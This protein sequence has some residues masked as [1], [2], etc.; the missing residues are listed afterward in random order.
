MP[1][2]KPAVNQTAFLKVGIFGF[3]GSGKTFT[4]MNIAIG[5]CKLIKNKRI[6]FFDTETG[7]DFQIERVKKAGLELGVIK[8][9]SFEDVCNVITETQ[10]EGYGI[11]IIDSISHIWKEITDSYLKKRNRQF[12]SLPDWGVIKN[13]WSRYTDLYV[14]SQ[15]HIIMCGRAGWQY[16]DFEN[17]DTGKMESRKTGTK[18]RVETETGFEPNLNLEMERITK[19][20]H[21]KGRKIASGWGHKCTVL[22]D[23]T[24]T[25]N[26]KVIYNPKFE[27]FMPVIKKLNLG[28]IHLGVDT[29][30]NSL[31]MIGDPNRDW[32]AAK[33]QHQ[34]AV[35]LL[36]EAL[37]VTG[38]AGTGKKEKEERTKVLIDL[39][40]TSSKTAIDDL[41]E[42]Q[43]QRILEAARAVKKMGERASD[44]DSR[45]SQ[46]PQMG[47][48]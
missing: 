22:K 38:L 45:S 32:D 44:A 21:T 47:S 48:R 43:T 9:R 42:I 29:S 35:E 13:L 8:S 34:I 17:E 36:D 25:M 39:L 12:I 4:A 2:L 7:S 15:M 40:G 27:D 14:N 28:A 5:I 41:K 18:M 20:Q 19:G 31:D 1:L 3:E 16:G 24:D 26:G 30:R 6:A 11:L 23:R 33:K 37:V 46:E 10:K